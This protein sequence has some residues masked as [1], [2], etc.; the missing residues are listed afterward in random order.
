LALRGGEWLASQPDR[1]TPEETMLVYTTPIDEF[2]DDEPVIFETF[3][4]LVFL[5]ILL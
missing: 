2:P 3:R 4:T 1:F 5:K